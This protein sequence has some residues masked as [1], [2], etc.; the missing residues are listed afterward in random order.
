MSVL[1]AC[2][3]GGDK[4]ALQKV[5]VNLEEELVKRVDEYAASL[6]VNRTAAVSVLLSMALQSNR[7]ASDFS[8]F[9]D[10]YEAEKKPKLVE[11]K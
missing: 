10:F 4:R 11:E 3:G 8:R 7:L 2:W 9:L 6:H 5:Q 1:V